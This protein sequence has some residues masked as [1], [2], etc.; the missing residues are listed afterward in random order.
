MP[1]HHAAA[2]GARVRVRVEILGSQTCG[3][4]GISQSVLIMIIPMIF[5]R[6]SNVARAGGGAQAQSAHGHEAS[7]VAAASVSGARRRGAR[8]GTQHGGALAEG[9]GAA[10]GSIGGAIYEE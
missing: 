8:V 9:G 5:T 10:D 2:A 4:V 6:T 3:F 1:R 7:G